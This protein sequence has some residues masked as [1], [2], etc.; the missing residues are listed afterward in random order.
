M[1]RQE[2][3]VQGLAQE[4]IQQLAMQIG[5]L[6]KLTGELFQSVSSVAPELRPL[7]GPM[8]SAMQQLKQQIAQRVQDKGRAVEGPPAE[9][10]PTA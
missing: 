6:E 8:I 2:G 5:Q 10:L 9:Q 3:G 4:G 1:S 7:F